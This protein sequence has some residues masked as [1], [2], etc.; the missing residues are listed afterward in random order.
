MFSG[1]KKDM[2]TAI[3]VDSGIPM[4]KRRFAL[5]GNLTAVRGALEGMKVGDSFMW[6][7]NKCAFLA[8]K[9]LGV[10]ITT[11]KVDG[12]GYRVWRKA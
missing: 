1:K 10:K 4:P 5:G 2:T 3:K 6:G 7:S 8:A 9:Q 11:R 12:E